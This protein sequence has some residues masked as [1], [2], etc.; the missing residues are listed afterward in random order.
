MLAEA[1][2]DNLAD[3]QPEVLSLVFEPFNSADTWC[4]GTNKGKD[5]DRGRF[6]DGDFHADRLHDLL[7]YDVSSRHW[8]G[9][10]RIRLVLNVEFLGSVVTVQVSNASKK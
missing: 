10:R 5:G 6:R 8:R 7:N 1:T 2:T 4:F 3:V 9:T